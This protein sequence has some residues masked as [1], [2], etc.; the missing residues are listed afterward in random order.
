M[1][2]FENLI[3]AARE[4]SVEDARTVLQHRPE[5]INNL[6][7]AG[8]TAL[9]Y[10]AFGGH[11]ELVRLLIENGA[12]INARDAKFGATPAGWAIEYLREMGGLLGIE[13][14]DLAHAIQ[15]GDVAWTARFLKRF[16]KLG[17]ALDTGG[18]P[19]RVLAEQS[20]NPEIIRLFETEKNS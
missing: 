14:S 1:T 4:G 17:E 10:A 20:G 16:P 9:H 18:T 8:A 7:A 2:D 11:C 3:T 15:Q 5:L 12:Y 19:L 6:D 13:I